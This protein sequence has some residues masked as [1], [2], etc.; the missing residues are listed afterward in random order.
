MK[1]I[2]LTT[3]SKGLPESPLTGPVPA[4]QR[5]SHLLAPE[6]KLPL[7]AKYEVLEKMFHALEYT[8][9]FTKGRDQTCIYHKIRKAV[10]NMCHRYVR[11]VDILW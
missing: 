1:R 8:I 2:K 7:P 3:L 4:F 5:Y 9:M 6:Q 10:E 11:G